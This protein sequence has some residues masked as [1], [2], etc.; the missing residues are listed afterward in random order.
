MT[1]ICNIEP[2]AEDIDPRQMINRTRFQEELS[3]ASPRSLRLTAADQKKVSSKQV[4]TMVALF[5]K[6]SV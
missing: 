5:F 2:P 6:S 3:G 1:L 4:A